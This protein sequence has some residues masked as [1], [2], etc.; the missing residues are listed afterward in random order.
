ESCE[1]AQKHDMVAEDFAFCLE[2]VPGCFFQLGLGEE[3]PSLHT[4]RFDFNDR[5]L[6]RG[7]LLFTA[8]AGGFDEPL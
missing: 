7:I 8:L 1:R 2:R 4:A 3:W 6:E 5:V